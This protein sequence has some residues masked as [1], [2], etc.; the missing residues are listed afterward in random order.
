ML[1]TKKIIKSSIIKDT[2]TWL[3][4]ITLAWMSRYFESVLFS[5]NKSQKKYWN[6]FDWKQINFINNYIIW[7]SNI[8]DYKMI[9]LINLVN[10]K[11]QYY[12]LIDFEIN[13]FS[14]QW[15]NYFYLIYKDF[16]WNIWYKTDLDLDNYKIEILGNKLNI[17]NNVFW[18]I[19]FEFNIKKITNLNQIKQNFIKTQVENNYLNIAD[20]YFFEEGLFE[21]KNYND[22][23]DFL[24]Q[25]AWK[26]IEDS[27]EKSIIFDLKKYDNELFPKLKLSLYIKTIDLH[28]KNNFYKIQKIIFGF[29]SENTL[30]YLNE[31]KNINDS[32]S[33]YLLNI[34]K[35]KIWNLDTNFKFNENIFNTD[36]NLIEFKKDFLILKYNFFALNELLVKLN[37]QNYLENSNLILNN[38]KIRWNLTK[39]NLEKTIKIYKKKL[40]LFIK[41]IKNNNK[42]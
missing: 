32:F 36:T 30:M 7:Y 9:C 20:F 13:T 33:W 37:W 34:S 10:Y 23:Y 21:I 29:I 15:K 8:F 4:K 12:F 14:I 27:N 35:E 1:L 39:E 28:T 22:F 24:N 11:S 3:Y 42:I 16:K 17:K 6:H 18:T 19:V 2:N 5:Y 41:K 31:N 25:F 40:T 38:A 26:K